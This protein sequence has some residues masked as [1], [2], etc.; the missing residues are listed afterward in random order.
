MIHLRKIKQGFCMVP[1]AVV[2][3][4]IA[5]TQPIV[6]AETVVTS[7]KIEAYDCKEPGKLIG[8]FEANSKL[9][10]QSYS[11]AD[12][13]YRVKFQAPNGSEVFAFCKPE[14][15][16]KSNSP[17]TAASKSS[18]F[19]SEIPLYNSILQ[20][21][22][23]LWSTTPSAFAR[24][25]SR[26]K[27]KWV[28]ATD[29]N[30]SRSGE[31]LS[32]LNL[33]VLETI[34]R[35]NGGKLQDVTLL[36]YGR[37]D[38]GAEISEGSFRE[39]LKKSEDLIGEFTGVT[40]TELFSAA[41]V[42]NLKKK[43]W[44]KPPFRIDL[45]WSFT[46]NTA[47]F[48]PEYVR[49]HATPL[50]PNTNIAELIKSETGT[51]KRP[52][53]TKIDDLKANVVHESNGDTY[54]KG[55]PMVD[56]GP[57]GYCAVATAERL[58]RYYG[59]DFDQN[60]LAKVSNTG[61]SGGTSPREMIKALGKIVSGYALITK[62]IK[63]WTSDGFLKEVNAYNLY[64]KKKNKKQI[65]I[66]SSSNASELYEEMDPAILKESKLQ[67]YFDKKKFS[68]GVINYVDKGTPLLWGVM[69]GYVVENP[70]LH[71]ARGGHMR[72]IIGYNKQNPE[73]IQVIYTDSWGA[74]HEFKHM[75]MDDAY[76]ISDDL[77]ATIPTL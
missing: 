46:K 39:L 63:E 56:Q 36:L 76:F 12:K 42:I 53:I 52:K 61:T 70:D 16:G 64:A 37:G 11:D 21:D 20:L 50:D 40:G 1:S 35:F 31:K 14:A 30:A 9:E 19:K 55:V 73:K 13:M 34:A 28:S 67:N 7:S 71:Q 24:N 60:Q 66:F 57:K 23:A 41:S 44:F 75:S 59:L 32:F 54:I 74:G 65:D 51:E 15:L 38:A 33:D 62:P 17:S 49:V 72:M 27:F 47:E 77:Y 8:Y 10:I 69:L 6:A 29:Q 26:F 2:L 43:S 5:W 3:F 68:E 58:L 22:N 45:E 18:E 48:R 25:Q 4:W